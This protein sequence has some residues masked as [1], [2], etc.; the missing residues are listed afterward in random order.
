MNPQELLTKG[1][2][3]IRTIIE[4]AGKPKEH[5][6]ST[7]K[8]FLEKIKKEE[9]MHIISE[10]IEPTEEKEGIFST[11]AELEI[12]C[13]DLIT[14]AGFCFDYMPSSIE[15]IKPESL[16][17]EAHHLAEVFNELQAKLHTVDALAKRL[18]SENQM[19][20]RNLNTSIQNQL[21]FFLGAK[22][23]TIEELEK[24]TGIPK[25]GLTTFLGHLIKQE[26]IKK[27]EDKYLKQDGTQKTD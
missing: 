19:L 7:L 3:Q 12:L 6:E 11:F 9:N 5:I 27:Q 2:L 16:K 4:L 14:I 17:L 1:Y 8:L 18:T 15:I 23:H 25:E 24:L 10:H 20:K 13:K 26:K 22:P 21:L